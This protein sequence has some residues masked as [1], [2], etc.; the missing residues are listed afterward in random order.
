MEGILKDPA[1]DVSP[2][3]SSGPPPEFLR[4]GHVRRRLERGQICPTEPDWVNL[5]EAGTQPG[6]I[7]EMSQHARHSMKAL[8]TLPVLSI[9]RH[10]RFTRNA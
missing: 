2:L 9:H 4:A 6:D 7:T 1:E 5:P 3:D 8:L 10:T